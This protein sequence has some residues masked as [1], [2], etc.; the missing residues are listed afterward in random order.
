MTKAKAIYRWWLRLPLWAR[1]PLALV[2]LVAL[3]VLAIEGVARAIKPAAPASPYRAIVE[4]KLAQSGRSSATLTEAMAK[5]DKRYAEIE[6]ELSNDK[7]TLQEFEAAI[8]ACD[9]VD[10]VDD[11]LAERIKSGR[12]GSKD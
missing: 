10:A 12:S 8:A 5:A 7:E 2:L 9:S 3:V 4:G 6:R 1:I 11:L